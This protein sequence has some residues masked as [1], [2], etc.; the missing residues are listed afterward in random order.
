MKIAV[1][2]N[3]MDNIGGAEIVALALARGLNAD[4]FTTNIDE[5][6]IQKMGYGDVL[7]RIYSLGKIPKN[8][9]LRQQLAFWKF[10][11]L[12]LEN[13]YD[14]YIIAGDWAMSGALN[15]KPNLWY[16]HSPLNELWAF[17]NYVREQVIAGWQK[18]FFDAWV[19]FNRR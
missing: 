1:F 9:P 12:N 17:K 8:A 19:A 13:Q 14:F 11:K 6:K 3:F 7:Q 16:I 10:K 2:H 4:L 18:P 15:H 5:D